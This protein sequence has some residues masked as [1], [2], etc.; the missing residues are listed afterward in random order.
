MTTSQ[1]PAVLSSSSITGDQVRNPAGEDLGEIKDLM[2]D[3]VNGRVAYAVLSFGGFLGFA[4]K[5]FAVPFSALAVDADQKK[6][7]L[8]VDKEILEKAHGFDKDNW[9]DMADR[10][11]QSDVHQLYE[12]EP[13]WEHSGH[14]QR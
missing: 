2:I 1:S 12:R 3:L 8:D 7:V 14:H 4:D 10:T 9:P 5:L 13:Y 11:W 6:F